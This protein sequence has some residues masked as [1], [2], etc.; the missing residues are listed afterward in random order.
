MPDLTKWTH[1]QSEST[2]SSYMRPLYARFLRNIVSFT[3][4][5]TTRTLKSCLDQQT[6]QLLA[7]LDVLFGVRRTR[8][9]LVQLIWPTIQYAE[10]LGHVLSTGASSASVRDT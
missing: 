9:V 8:E 7:G 3:L 1:C 10:L 6:T 2:A 5:R 4:T